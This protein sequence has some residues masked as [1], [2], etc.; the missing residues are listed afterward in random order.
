MGLDKGQ[1]DQ[2]AIIIS[3]TLLGFTI[4]RGCPSP[5]WQT[6]PSTK[7]SLAARPT[8]TK[9]ADCGKDVNTAKQ[10][11]CAFDL[12]MGQWVPQLCFD[13]ALHDRYLE[14]YGWPRFWDISLEVPAPED[15]VYTG[16]YNGTFLPLE[17]HFHHCA[18][19]LQHLMRGYATGAPVLE[20]LW[21]YHHA[22]HCTLLLETQEFPGR[23][24]TF[25]RTDFASCVQPHIS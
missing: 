25:L 4:S 22:E 9:L 10:N 17:F 21:S 20:S 6:A 14:N 19:I 24:I 23:N 2:A 3:S 18:Y 16:D 8:F 5:H 12:I 11:G 1:C 13:Q 15:V 7:P